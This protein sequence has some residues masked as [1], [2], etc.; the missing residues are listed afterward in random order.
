MSCYLF[1]STESLIGVLRLHTWPRDVVQV[2][3]ALSDAR[4]RHRFLNVDLN[5]SCGLRTPRGVPFLSVDEK[6]E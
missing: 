3:G 6:A 4:G 1:P 2:G 5:G